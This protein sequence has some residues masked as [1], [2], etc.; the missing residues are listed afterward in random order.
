MA[1]FKFTD[2]ATILNDVFGMNAEGKTPVLPDLSNIVDVGKTITDGY[3][4]A[5]TGDALVNKIRAQVLLTT[6][7]IH[8][9]VDCY[10]NGEDWAGITE[11]YR[12]GVGKF[13]ASKM[14]DA[15]T[16]E[17]LSDGT[18]RYFTNSNSFEDLFG[19]EMPTIHARYFDK[20]ATYRKKIT[21]AP[22][23]FANAFLSASAMSQFIN[24]IGRKVEEQWSYAKELLEYMAM[25]VGVGATITGR[26]TGSSSTLANTCVKLREWTNMIDLYTEIKTI[27]RELQQY[28]NKYA[29]SDFVTSVS[30]DNLV[31]YMY[32]PLYDKLIASVENFT[33]NGDIVKS[34]LGKFKP[35]PYFGN[36][37][38]PDC[39]AYKDGSNGYVAIRNI[40][41]I[42]CDKRLFGCTAE[43]K[44]VT[45][46][47]VPNEDVTNFFH[48]ATAKYR[49]NTDLPVVV[50]CNCN[51]L[52]DVFDATQL[53]GYPTA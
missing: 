51:S 19:K 7:F 29:A 1:N 26:S 35:L 39:I 43:H 50:G 14:F 31:C 23:Q 42:I 38:N 20:V 53:E 11:V 46:Q 3:T 21:I 10:Y 12:V 13:S 41:Y 27:M 4:L 52:A 28:N 18:T 9:G 17:T 6:D 22:M 45:S 16:D 44:K 47:Y 33:M 36:D 40:D 2:I 48:M 32:A 5:T 30:D 24:E 34:I 15:V 8:T 25:N 37:A 49:V